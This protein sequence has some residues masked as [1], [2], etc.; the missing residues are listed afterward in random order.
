M[1]NLALNMSTKSI[2]V[3][4]TVS[5]TVVCQPQMHRLMGYTE[6]LAKNTKDSTQQ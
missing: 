6:Y 3:N 1:I 2:Y 4:F 5:P